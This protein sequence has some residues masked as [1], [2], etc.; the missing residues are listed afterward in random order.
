MKRT[1]L[2][3]PARHT[4]CLCVDAKHEAA[5]TSEIFRPVWQVLSGGTARCAKGVQQAF[6]ASSQ[7][8]HC[9]V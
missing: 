4:A 8:G 3:G 2:F 6:Y 7:Q 1:C 9:P 5:I